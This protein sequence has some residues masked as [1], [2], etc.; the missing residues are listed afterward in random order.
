M[1]HPKETNSAMNETTALPKA[2]LAWSS[3]KGR[4]W[5][6]HG[7][8]E[9]QQIEVVALLTTVNR[10]HQRGG[11]HA[12]RESLLAR[13]AAAAD[14]PLVLVPIPSP[15][16]NEEYE[17]AMSAAIQRA[18]AEGVTHM[19]FGDLFLEDIRRYR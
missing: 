17:R 1:V 16:T 10:T 5:A 2:W 3:G 8:R 11:M 15:C 7:V 18:R 4:A 6:L 9:Q 13:Q 19:I 14:L 12:V